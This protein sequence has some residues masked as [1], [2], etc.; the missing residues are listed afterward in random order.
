MHIA[1]VIVYALLAA[2]GAA[3][4]GHGV[5]ALAVPTILAGVAGATVALATHL[6]RGTRPVRT[7]ALTIAAILV[8]AGIA[9]APANTDRPFV[10]I[11]DVVIAALLT[12]FTLLATTNR[13]QP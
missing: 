7:G 5:D 10:I 1:A 12:A 9:L 11:V 13:Q 6:N 8:A 3:A 4:L 2:L